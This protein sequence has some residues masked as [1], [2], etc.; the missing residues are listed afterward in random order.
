MPR[1]SLLLLGLLSLG[2]LIIPTSSRTQLTPVRPRGKAKMNGFY[3]N[4]QAPR[5]MKPDQ[6][7]WSG[8]R[9]RY[10]PTGVKPNLRV[11]SQTQVRS[12]NSNGNIQVNDGSLDNIQSFPP[13]PPRFNFNQSE[14]SVA[15]HGSNIVAVY[16]TDAFTS[17]VEIGG[18]LLVDHQFT[19]GFSNSTDGGKTWTTS[20]MP[21]IPG[22]RMTLG[23]PV[24]EVDRQG[25]FHFVG[26]GLDEQL[27]FTIQTN[28][29]TDGGRSWSDAV[30]VQQDDN[31]DKPWLAVGPDPANQNR[32]NLYVTWTSFQPQR[33][34]LATSAELRFSRSIDSGVTWTT[35]TI[36]SPASDPN[37]ANH[38][39]R[40]QFS[41]PYVDPITGR[42]YVPFVRAAADSDVDVIQMLVSDDAG[43]TFS[44]ATLN[45][46]A[47]DPTLLFFVLPGEFCDCGEFGGQHL[48]IR[49]TPDIGGRS[50]LP[51]FVNATRIFTQPAIA[52]TNGIVYLAYS[53]SASPISGDP[54]GHS[55]VLLI[56][57]TD[58]GATWTAPIQVNR[59]VGAD[60]HHVQPSLAVGADP[61]AVHIGYYT[62]HSDGTLDVDLATSLDM[63]N[64][65]P[66]NRFVRVTSAPFSLAPTNI[67]LSADITFNYSQSAPCYGLGE[68]MSV[69]FPK[70][71]TNG[72]QDTIHVLWTDG[73][74]TVTHP[75][76]LF[77]PLTGLTHPQQDVFFRA[78]KVK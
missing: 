18:D 51:R 17:F 44:F 29:S 31:G 56:R 55:N 1:K 36:L 48:V 73:R 58:G 60:I 13:A 46:G 12:G 34:P 14:T 64:S 32:D 78:V 76:N 35:K 49:S 33:P 74:N 8:L 71:V 75:P 45:P 67:P 25:N 40:I 72:N 53:A 43:E 77:D 22:S 3:Q 7:G 11:E 9:V 37:P 69:K 16:N 15:A 23:D 59:D 30:V 10:T 6:I 70:G 39:A 24:V 21:P 41:N 26:L 27:R 19:S 66:S 28:R 68:Y 62:Q 20:F 4:I 61:T 65:F 63:G 47:P 38:H 50:G 5:R 52:G 57:S 42:L 2:V 54:S